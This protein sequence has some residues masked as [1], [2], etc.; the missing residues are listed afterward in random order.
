M[1]QS[2]NPSRQAQWSQEFRLASTG[3]GRLDWVTGLYAFSQTV[4]TNGVTEYGADAAYWLLGPS[5]PD[6]LLDGYT[7]FNDSRIETRSYA[8]FGQATWRATERLRATLGLR[9]TYEEKD[10][11]YAATTT[12]GLVTSDPTLIARRLGV[13]R[14]QAYAADISGDDVS[15]QF[16]LSYDLSERVMVY[17]TLARGYKSG[18][19]N[20][21][22]IPT[23]ADGTPALNSATVE[24]ETVTT[25][26]LGIK[27][28][29][30]GRRLTLN[31]A[32]YRTDIRDYQAN[33]VDAGPGALRGYLANVDRVEIRGVEI[34]LVAYPTD[35]LDL[36]ASLAWTDARYVDFVNGPCPLERIGPSTVACDLS[37]ERLP[38]VSPWA[39]SA[40]G[41]WRAPADPFGRAGEAFLGADVT[42]RSSY[43]SD[44]S[45]SRYLE[46]D[47][48]A[49]V[50]LR[51][52]FRAENGW[53]AFV[54]AR[55]ALDQDYMSFLS[56]QSGNSGLIIGQP[57]DPR[58]V[59]VTLRARY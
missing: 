51:A 27:T 12:G 45:V 26:E 17:G 49:L 48:Y 14:P 1:R 13:A 9:Y 46:I 4:E 15:G 41:E 40:G 5:F 8:V 6:A 28:Q 32:A 42:Y 55:N 43:S 22:G 30:F 56:V 38:G 23:Q 54:W 50:N 2:A 7:V 25:W 52:G 35:Q 10:G 24:P 59:G 44:A 16:A 31:A 39:A 57:G 58:T 33:V 29:S 53:E 36:Y 37:G 18:G 47:G 3:E 11:T 34:D 21:A 20:M 19:I